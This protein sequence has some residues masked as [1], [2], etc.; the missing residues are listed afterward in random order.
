MQ[1]APNRPKHD[2]TQSYNDGIV[3]I[4]GVTNTAQAGYK[5]KQ[6]LF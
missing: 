4:Y 2:V 3:R 5:P 1:K 6:D